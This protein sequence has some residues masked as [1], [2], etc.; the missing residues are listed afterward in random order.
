ME[1]PLWSL[2]MGI[3]SRLPSRLQTPRSPW[4]YFFC[5]W[6]F[7]KTVRLFLE[8]QVRMLHEIHWLML[9]SLVFLMRFILTKLVKDSFTPINKMKF[10]YSPKAA[11]KIWENSKPKPKCLLSEGNK[12]PSTYEEAVQ[13]K[14]DS[15]IKNGTWKVTEI[16]A[17]RKALKLR[18]I[19]IP[20]VF[21]IGKL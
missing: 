10:H 9:V 4:R 17:G 19:E 3:E 5:E 8:D 11:K 6:F 7:W 2:I 18:W 20:S 15:M 21:W 12:D 1:R 14:Y 13:K 16:P